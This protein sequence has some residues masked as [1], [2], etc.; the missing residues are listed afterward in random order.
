MSDVFS[1]YSFKLCSATDQMVSS[2]LYLAKMY[3]EGLGV[4]RNLERAVYWCRRAADNAEPGDYDAQAVLPVMVEVLRRE[5]KRETGSIPTSRT[6][7][8]KKGKKSIIR[9]FGRLPEKKATLLELLADPFH[10]FLDL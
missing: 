2:L 3:S 1:A 5:Q 7:R 8:K 6:K 4:K 10:K 9:G